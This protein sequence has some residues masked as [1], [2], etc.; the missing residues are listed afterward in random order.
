VDIDNNE[1]GRCVEEE[2]SICVELKSFLKTLNE[3]IKNEV[4]PNYR[5]WIDKTNNWK[6]KYVTIKENSIQFGV[7]PLELVQRIQDCLPCNS[8]IASDV[9][10]NQMWVAQAIRVKKGQRIL[11][12]SGLGSMGYALP[13]SI[14]AKI[15]SPESSVVAFM[16][17]GGVQINL[18]ELELLKLKQLNIKVVVFRNERLGLIKNTQD[19]YYGERNIGCA[20]P[21]FGCPN[22]YFI[23]K[24]YDIKYLLIK[25]DEDLKLIKNIFAEN[26]SY[27]IEVLVDPEFPLKTRYD[28][29]DVMQ[30]ESIDE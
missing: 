22:L 19:K 20:P 14:A 5:A 21:E 16:G 26:Y 2:L 13:A 1:L 4:L 12:S 8:V 29:N 11:N 30:I 6:Q 15:Y 10:Q 27:I 17:D 23:A 24:A 28:L 3:N 25:T 18:Q 9:G 7:S